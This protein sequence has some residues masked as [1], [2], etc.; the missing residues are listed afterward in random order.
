MSLPALPDRRRPTPIPLRPDQDAV[1]DASMRSLSRA[2]VAIALN[3]NDPSCLPDDYVRRVWAGDHVLPLVLRA[4][5]SPAMVANT[6]ALAPI[7]SA[8][9]SAL[10]PQSAAAA[11]IK[12]GF[13]L[14]FNGAASISVPGLSIPVANFVAEGQAIPAAEAPG[15]DTR[16]SPHKLAVIMTA[17]SEMLRSPQAEDLVRQMLIEATGP[18]LDAALLDTNPASDERP[19]GL[20]HGIA[21]LPTAVGL[22]DKL[23]SVLE[24]I[25]PVSG[26]GAVAVI[27]TPKLRVSIDLV[28]ARSPPFV[29]LASSSLPAGTIIGV[30]LNALVSAVAGPPMIQASRE[31]VIHAETSPRTD[32][33]GGI[34]ATPLRSMWQADSVALRLRWG[35]SWSLRSP[36]NV[37][38]TTG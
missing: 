2:T 10:V 17:T 32:I 28:L 25:A 12:Q 29:V 27:T 33:G 4:A 38:W 36:Q 22:I 13:G 11:L 16:L 37:A 7:S 19:A 31:A 5:V 8:F 24:A 26:N 21:P 9:L 18:A 23:L 35:I 3:A 6:P 20:R 14:D 34:M 30:A 15:T 1:N